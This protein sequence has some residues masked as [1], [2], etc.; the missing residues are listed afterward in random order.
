MDIEK[1]FPQLSIGT[2][3]IRSLLLSYRRYARLT[4]SERKIYEEFAHGY[5]ITTRQL[6]LHIK[7]KRKKSLKK[8]YFDIAKSW[9]DSGDINPII[10]KCASRISKISDKYLAKEFKF[11]GF[12]NINTIKY[13]NKYG[14]FMVNRELDGELLVYPK[15]FTDNYY[16]MIRGKHP[17]YQNYMGWYT[18][19]GLTRYQYSDFKIPKWVIGKKP[20]PF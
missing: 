18:I 20:Q 3:E 8:K 12:V 5:S 10:I 19:P 6:A 11:H 1:V 9:L 2:R 14:Y 16:T 15:K 4:E 7:S 13:N 17:N